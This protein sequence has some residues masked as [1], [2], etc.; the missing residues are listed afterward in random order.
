VLNQALSDEG[1]WR[2]GG[3]TPRF[4]EVT[5]WPPYRAAVHDERSAARDDAVQLHELTA[6]KEIYKLNVTIR[7]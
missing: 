1:I 3:I 5:L 7:S 4:V 6:R 2:S